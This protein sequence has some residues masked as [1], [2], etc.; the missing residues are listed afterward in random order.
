MWRHGNVNVNGEVVPTSWR[1]VDGVVVA[2]DLP[3]DMA[4]TADVR[5]DGGDYVIENMSRE[6][7][8]DRVTV[9]LITRAEMDRRLAAIEEQKAKA[10]A[11]FEGRQW[12]PSAVTEAAGNVEVKSGKSSKG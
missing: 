3:K 2:I 7:F 5:I 8:P 9:P 12:P 4:V 6:E 10:L 1:V 11:E